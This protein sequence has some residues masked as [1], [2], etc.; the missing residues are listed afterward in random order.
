VNEQKATS[1]L[2]AIAASDDLL[3]LAQE[4]GRLGIFEWQVP[5]GRLLLSPQFLAIY[6]I[7]DFD[8]QYQTWMNCVFREDV[9]R[10]ADMTERAFAE[11]QR[12]STVE[13]RIIRP[14]DGA[15]AW[16]EAR[17][18]NFY[19][20]DGRP[21][22]VVGVNV[23][24]TERKRALMQ[25]RSFTDT[26]EEAVRAR[27][28]ELE[29]ENLAR[30]KAEESLRQAQKM[31]VVGQ[32]TGGV[33]HDFN[34]LLTIVLGGLDSIGRHLAAI[35]GSPAAERIARGR[36]MAVEGAKRAVTL[37]SRLLAFSRRQPLDPKPVDVSKLIGSIAELLH[38]SLGEPISLETVL[39]AGLWRLYADTNQLESSLLNLALNSRDAMPRGGK[40]TIETAN[41]F[42]DEA[43]VAALPEPVDAG[44][45]VMIAVTDNGSGMDQTTLE[46]AF[47]PFFTTKEIG[48]GTG[49][50]LSQ[51]YGFVRQSSGHVRI[52]SE[53]GQG[54]CVKL[55]LPRYSGSDEESR[56][57]P[58]PRHSPRAIGEEIILVAEDDEALRSYTVQILAE[59]GYHVVEAPDGVAA[60]QIVQARKDIDLLFTDIVMPGGLNGRQLAD[61]AQ[62]LR[63]GLK[64]LFTTGYTRNAVI[65]HG[66]LDRGVHLIAK[67]FSFEELAAKIRTLLDSHTL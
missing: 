40:V 25:L 53:R 41:C 35:E 28:L 38:R 14:S 44:Q 54:T 5:S 29:A 37:T 21:T 13:F 48:K 30:R 56:D 22:R 51:V 34:N 6:G 65:H 20:D 47:E 43:Y 23:D 26:L 3:A 33:A 19:D 10:I 1:E 27:T 7:K 32:L 31:E 4:A 11:R 24:I 9:V 60:L 57:Q 58:S 12:E 45:Y 46:R 39:S 64:V 59:L 49:L 2:P 63:P 18:F 61:Q 17:S 55:Y 50:G 42:L 36:D 52:Y 15:L 62:H 8:G 16:M 66:R 67:P